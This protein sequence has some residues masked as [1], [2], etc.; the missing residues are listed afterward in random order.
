MFIKSIRIFSTATDVVLREVSFHKG[1]NLVVDTEDSSRHNKVGKSTFLKLIDILLGAKDKD[2]IYT[3]SETGS[4]II[5]LRN[6]IVNQ[7][8]AAEMVITRSL[9][10]DSSASDTK[11]RVELFPRGACYIDGE[12]ISQDGYRKELN[13]LF[14]DNE[15]NVPTFRQLIHSFV[16]VSV[17][18]DDNSF[19]KT[20]AQARN[21]DY[22]AIYNFLF[23]LSD[24]SLDEMLG[25]LNKEKSRTE[26]AQKRYKR[27]NN[28]SDLSEQEQILLAL[29]REHDQ[30]KHAIDD[31]ID[32]YEYKNN[33]DC[34]VQI[35]SEY[36]R[37]TDCIS[38]I[39]H[40]ISRNKEAIQIA[41]QERLRQADLELS[42]KFFE[43]V[44][45]MIPDINKS[46]E[47]MVKFNDKLCDNK[48]RYFTEVEQ[49]L[50][51][52]RE[53]FLDAR[54]ELVANN[55][56]FIS[57]VAEDRISEYETLSSRLELLQQDIGKRN[58]VVLTLQRFDKE[59][60]QIEKQIAD[61]ASGGSARNA[62]DD[63]WQVM[64]DSFNAFFTP[65]AQK[66]NNEK[67]ILVYSSDTSKFPL[68]I[69]DLSGSS[70]GTRKSLI[71]AFDLA[72]Q[73]FANENRIITPRFV[74][75]DVI[76]NIEGDDLRVIIEQSNAIDMQYIVAV[77]KEKLDSSGI[78]EEEQARLQI[79]QLSEHDKLFE[80]TSLS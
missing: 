45:S 34:I 22:R 27:V 44:C 38:D 13:I 30:I 14:F 72:Y 32:P 51:S 48:I 74:V 18:G 2:H 60:C 37:L 64:M 1:A 69:S 77:L 12:R 10:N 40:K 67:P 79:L 19:L 41:E 63:W 70:T 3:D 16:R 23:N 66:I 21:T 26:E 62:D 47:D 49:N 5:A 73:Q 6:L 52:D 17:S 11:L 46:F 15:N 7:R 9:E 68:L 71:A 59:K 33:R 55:K 57:L 35:R 31:I 28:V 8:L 43:E 20:L 42:R 36:A 61:F 56:Q 75:H 78:L 29:Q 58:E 25:Q 65:L 53:A 76:E 50:S 39:E 24:P 4:V 80:G 54:D